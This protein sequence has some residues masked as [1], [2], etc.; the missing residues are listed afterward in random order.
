MCTHAQFVD[1][2]QETRPE[3]MIMWKLNML[4]LVVTI[5]TYVRSFVQVTWHLRSITIDIIDKKN[6]MNSPGLVFD[7]FIQSFAQEQMSQSF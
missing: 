2:M 6:K 1:T 4:N 3:F 7:V 5:A